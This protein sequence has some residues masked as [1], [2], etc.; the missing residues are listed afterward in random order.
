LAVDSSDNSEQTHFQVLW[1]IK[2]HLT[3]TFLLG[4]V[5][6]SIACPQTAATRPHI[7]T[8]LWHRSQRWL[9][10]AAL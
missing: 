2:T 1:T 3:V 7:V 8:R 9:Q 10:P 4:Y 6:S 5:E